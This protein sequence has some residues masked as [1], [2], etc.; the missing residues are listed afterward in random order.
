MLKV[1]QQVEEQGLDP[2]CS[3]GSVGL[4]PLHY[5]TSTPSSCVGKWVQQESAAVC[6]DDDDTFPGFNY[7]PDFWATIET[8]E[9]LKAIRQIMC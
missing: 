4:H 9:I 8:A 3:L 7:T 1:T 2:G 5:H 6:S